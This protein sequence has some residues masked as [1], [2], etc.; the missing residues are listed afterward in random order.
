MKPQQ[1]QVQQIKTKVSSSQRAIIFDS[2]TL[3]SFSMNG[4]TDLIKSLKGIFDGKFLITSDV[5]SEI[6]DKPINIKRFELEALKLKQLLDENVLE[7]PSSLGIDDREIEERTNKVLDKAN[8]VFWGNKNPVKLLDLGES[9]C[10][11]LSSILNEKG[12]MNVLAVDERTTR[13]L[14]EDPEDLKR[15]LQKKLH[16][17]ITMN[18]ENLKLFRGFKIIRSPELVYVAY[19]KDLVKIKDGSLVL[20][21]LLYAMKFKG[22]SI[23]DQEIEEIKRIG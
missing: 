20:D 7:M 8:S 15:W 2:G 9:S 1:K 21:A 23:S 16:V 18:S 5:K 14:V 17:K 22:A 4:L 11:A 3:I 10:L 13:M 6:I 12:I 19:K